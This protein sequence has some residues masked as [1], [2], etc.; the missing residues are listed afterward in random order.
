MIRFFGITVMRSSTHDAYS[1]VVRAAW[2][3]LRAINFDQNHDYSALM[4]LNLNL[5][6]ALSY[7]PIEDAPK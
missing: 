3:L 4:Y 6:S 2:P 1:D 7:A 5:A